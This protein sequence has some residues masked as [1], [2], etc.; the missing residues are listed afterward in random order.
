MEYL[1]SI[2]DVTSQ[3]ENFNFID[4]TDNSDFIHGNMFDS[5]KEF[6]NKSLYDSFKKTSS[7]NRLCFSTSSR[8]ILLKVKLNNV[9]EYPN[10]VDWNTKGFDVYEVNNGIYYHKTVFAPFKENN[11][12]SEI[13]HNK[14]NSQLCVFLPNFSNIEKLLIGIE[15][16]SELKSVKYPNEENPI[17]FYGNTTTQGASAS[18]SG[19]SYPNII[20]RKKNMDMITFIHKDNE[21]EYS[22]IKSLIQSKNSNIVLLLKQNTFKT[23]IEEIQKLKKDT[24]NI[25]ILI[26]DDFN[27]DNLNYD[28]LNNMKIFRYSELFEINELDYLTTDKKHFTDYGMYILAKKICENITEN[29]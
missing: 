27:D 4:I 23:S 3:D 21:N 26:D 13:I 16:D 7:G 5:I 15:K 9:E 22:L 20:S 29:H 1:K 28:E 10:I 18:R 6:L 19:N 24:Q 12:F 14:P 2:N 8:K 25:I 11:I 17:I